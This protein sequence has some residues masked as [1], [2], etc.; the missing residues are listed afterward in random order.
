MIFKSLEHNPIMTPN[1]A[2]V[3]FE[4]GEDEVLHLR[5]FGKD[6]RIEIRL[7]EEERAITIVTPTRM[8]RQI[9][10]ESSGRPFIPSSG[11][12]DD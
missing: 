12:G 3:D 8:M 2:V 1:Q 4:G 11:G 7:D 6:L 9:L 5:A 10:T